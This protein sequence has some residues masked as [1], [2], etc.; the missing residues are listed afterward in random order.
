MIST[1]LTGEEGARIVL[2]SLMFGEI[3]ACRSATSIS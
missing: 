2:S 3:D 1:A